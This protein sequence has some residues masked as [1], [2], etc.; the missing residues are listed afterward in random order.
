MTRTEEEFLWSAPF[1]RYLAYTDETNNLIRVTRDG[2]RR[3]MDMPQL[4]EILHEGKPDHD[5]MRAE[6]RKHA[7]EIAE[8][9]GLEQR[10]GFALLYAHATVSLWGS[11]EVLVGDVVGAW[12]L[13]HAA[14]FEKPP[15]SDVK[16]QV[17]TYRSLSDPE[18]VAHIITELQRG[19]KSDLKQGSGQFE[20]ILDAVGLGGGMDATVREGVFYLQQFR[21]LIVHRGGVADRRFVTNCSA[22]GFNV[23]ERVTVTE[24]LYWQF[25]MAASLYAL[26][27]RNRCRVADNFRP[28]DVDLPSGFGDFVELVRTGRPHAGQVTDVDREMEA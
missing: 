14:L 22:L 17:G 28:W 9:A 5:G 15:I 24:D 19:L 27:I 16:L 6:S 3:V 25:W 2:V 1:K 21:H 10:R 13:E 20:S 12:L 18:L 8:L 26:T 23:G 4:F 11:L 7:A